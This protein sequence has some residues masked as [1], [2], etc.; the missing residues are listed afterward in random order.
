MAAPSFTEL[1]ATEDPYPE[2]HRLR[3]EDPVHFFA[4][5]GFWVVFRHDDVKQLLNDPEHVTGDKRSWE[6]YAPSPEGS[7]LRWAEDN[8][9]F[10]VKPEEHARLRR[11]VAAA[12][13]PRAIRRMEEQIREVVD[14]VARPLKCRSGEVIDLN[15][16]FASVIPNT[17]ISRITGVPPA[18]DDEERFRDL[19]QSAIAGFLPFTPPELKAK[20]DVSF[21]ELV[22]WVREL[23]AKRRANPEEDLITD[24]LQAQ[25]EDARLTE[26]DIVRLV[27]GLVAAGSET[28][29]LGGMRIARTLLEN[30][31]PAERLRADRSLVPGSLDEL[32]RFSLGGPAGTVRFA[33]R[34]FRLR[35]KE[36][37]RG[38]MIMLSFGG[39]N[40]DPA[41]FAEPDTLD[42]DRGV[43]DL[44]VF[45]HGPHYCLG[46]N[47]ARQEMACML[48]A[49]LDILTPGSQI[50]EAR[51]EYQ[52]AGLFKRPLNLPVRIAGAASM[53]P[54]SSRS[55]ASSRWTRRAGP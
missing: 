25:D 26:D 17:V 54:C 32:I 24:L 41:V 49:L 33:R 11:L 42:L 30:P 2:I 48:D 43:R 3:A 45:G 4:D 8:S 18:G 31:E 28:T 22:A 23:C 50:E 13:T 12:F 37:C 38:Q 16:G 6:H 9:L 44:L 27:T 19:A 46:A 10:A 15:R 21:G 20:A 29:A 39:A 34:D 35:G 7:L 47:L 53:S 5:L 1:V 55:A 14:R 52:D 51:R 40:R 36:I